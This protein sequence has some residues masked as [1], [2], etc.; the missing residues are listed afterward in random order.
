M[1]KNKKL[2]RQR[3]NQKEHSESRLFPL[4]LFRNLK[5]STRKGACAKSLRRGFKMKTGV[6]RSKVPKSETNTIKGKSEITNSALKTHKRK[7][8]NFLDTPTTA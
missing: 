4:L 5:L 7:R 6:W 2:K 8:K 3:H 1:G